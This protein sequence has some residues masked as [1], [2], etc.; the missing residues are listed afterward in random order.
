MR[1][2]VVMAVAACLAGAGCAGDGDGD[3]RQ[4]QRASEARPVESIPLFNPLGIAPLGYVNMMRGSLLPTALDDTRRFEGSVDRGR[5]MAELDGP[6]LAYLFMALAGMEYHPVRADD[7]ASEEVLDRT[8]A[9]VVHF[10]DP[11]SP[12]DPAS[13][14]NTTGLEVVKHVKKPLL[15]FRADVV[16]VT[17]RP[18]YAVAIRGTQVK[19]PSFVQTFANLMADLTAA[20]VSVDR[21]QLRGGALDTLVDLAGVRSLWGSRLK[22]NF[23]AREPTV[24]AGILLS[25]AT[26]YQ[27]VVSEVRA[28]VERDA[29]GGPAPCVWL[30]GHSLGGGMAPLLAYFLSHDPDFNR[31][32]KV[33]GVYT[34]GAPRVANRAFI[35]DYNRSSVFGGSGG[36]FGVGAGSSL[37][38]GSV[39]LRYQLKDDPVPHVPPFIPHNDPDRVPNGEAGQVGELVAE[40][41]RELAAAKA[42]DIVDLNALLEKYRL[43]DLARPRSA[44]ELAALGLN[45]AQAELGEL[46]WNTG[47]DLLGRAVDAGGLKAEGLVIEQVQRFR[48]VDHLGRTRW[49]DR[50]GPNEYRIQTASTTNWHHINSLLS[51]TDSLRGAV[52]ADRAGGTNAN[53]KQFLSNSLGFHRAPFYA[54]VLYQHT[55]AIL[56]DPRFAGSTAP[57]FDY[58]DGAGVDDRL[59]GGLTLFELSPLKA[60]MQALY[61]PAGQTYFGC[62]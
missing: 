23:D 10:G 24:H 17:G 38:L 31:R 18:H 30:T 19:Q 15:G 46:L 12:L 22:A 6:D 44:A 42:A 34:Y 37:D 48:G 53:V 25:T 9:R 49:A 2:F 59:P 16:R 5:L 8:L 28:A 3:G 50:L 26:L 21:G 27:A 40:A 62:R 57:H 54:A 20:G 29:P 36:P 55:G 32:A 33:C 61:D 1:R 52:C 11:D 14:P 13:S 39:T 35:D 60:R 45:D 4:E 58:P 56:A 7:T 47:S 51:F 41:L 43:P